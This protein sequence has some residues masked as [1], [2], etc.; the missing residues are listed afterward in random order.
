MMY[1]EK[2]F[3]SLILDEQNILM[4]IC[5]SFLNIAAPNEPASYAVVMRKTR[6]RAY[7][8]KETNMR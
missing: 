4:Y 1:A 3:D 5:K 7:G 8:L 6:R 2:A